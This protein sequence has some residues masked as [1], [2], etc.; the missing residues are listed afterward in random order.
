MSEE[1]T[2]NPDGSTT[3]ESDAGAGAGAEPDFEEGFA[4]GAGAESAEEI[5]KGTD[6]AIFLVLGFLVCAVLYY[7]NYQRN[8]KKQM[9]REAFFYDMDGDK[10]CPCALRVLYGIRTGTLVRDTHIAIDSV[11]KYAILTVVLQDCI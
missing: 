3:F 7:L 6:P 2:V 8:K 1:A 10:V 5:V 11:H 4:E 9:E